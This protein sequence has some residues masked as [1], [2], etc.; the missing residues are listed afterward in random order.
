[1]TVIF[2]KKNKLNRQNTYTHIT[3]RYL[4]AYKKFHIKYDLILSFYLKITEHIICLKEK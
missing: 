2:N 1:M 3:Y 4:L